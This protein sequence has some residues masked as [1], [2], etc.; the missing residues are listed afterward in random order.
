MDELSKR[1]RFIREKNGFSQEELA[2]VLGVSFP[3]VNSWERGKSQPYPKH[4]K[5]IENLYK[6]ACGS[7]DGG[8]HVFVVE[9]DP[10]ASTILQE[11]VKL[12]MADA[13]VHPFENGYDALLQIGLIKPQVVLLD[14]MMP[15]IDGIEVFQKMK[16]IQD[17][18]D[19]NVIFV[20]AVTDPQVL[21][22]AK[23]ARP[24]GIVNKPVDRLELNAL[25]N[26]AI[27]IQV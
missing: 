9:D 8:L 23:E 18:K 11:Y 2:R 21:Y 16:A 14:I 17:L 15:G 7:Q 13:V 10:A 24:L 25:L 1:I 22:R 5:K 26:Q 27:G 12:V 20:S 4:R 19:L 6:E 3:T